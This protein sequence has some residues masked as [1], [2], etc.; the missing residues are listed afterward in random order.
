MSY[1]FE[2]GCPPR[3]GVAILGVPERL[4]FGTRGHYSRTL[5][6]SG[7]HTRQLP[8]G[9]NC[10]LTSG[11]NLAVRYRAVHRPGFAYLGGTGGIR[12]PLAY[13]YHLTFWIIFATPRCASY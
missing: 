4:S 13:K 3:T 11:R 7:S 2:S 6:D 9:A 5:A 12:L 1:Q 8:I 10:P